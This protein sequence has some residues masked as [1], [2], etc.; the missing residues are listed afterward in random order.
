MEKILLRLQEKMTELESP[1]SDLRYVEVARYRIR[2]KKGALEEVKETSSRGIG[3]RVLASGAFGFSATGDLTEK[4]LLFH[5]EQAYRMAVRFSKIRHAEVELIPV[6]PV[7]TRWVMP[8]RK[9]PWKLSLKEKMAPLESAE[10]RLLSHAWMDSTSGC[11]DFIRKTVIFVS[12][13]G[14]WIEQSLYRTGGWLCGETWVGRRLSRPNGREKIRRSWPGPSGVY[15]AQGY[16]AIENFDFPGEAVRIGEELKEIRKSPE[17]PCGTF[18]LILKGSIL[19]LQIHETFGHAS[20]ADRVYGYEDNF[21]GRTFLT[22]GLMGGVEV[23]SPKVTLVSDARLTLGPGTG[24]F[25]YDDEGV[26][27][28]SRPLIQKGIFMGYMT[29]RETAFFLNQPESSANMV[30]QDWAHYPLIR[31]TNTSLLPGKG[32]L[33]EIIAETEEGFLLDTELSWSVDEMRLDFHIG[34]E[35]GYHIQKGKIKGLVKF[36]FYYGNSLDFWR[37]CDRVAG[38]KE[39]EFWGFADC[40]KGGPYQEAFT[41]H[42]LSPARFRRVPFGRD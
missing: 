5:L 2:T 15:R 11:L 39:W 33:K 13:H 18:D 38:K 7:K 36:P 3:F 6:N 30:A 16:E 42:G 14:S 41:G 20:E 4:S 17:T 12:S 26:P 31:M 27:A 34:A 32:T 35:M 9:D 10:K 21:G 24:S 19:A 37:S 40:G 1:Y 29:S 22:P 28:I 25:A 23:A 8:V